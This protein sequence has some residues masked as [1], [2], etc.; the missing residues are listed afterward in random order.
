MERSAPKKY[1]LEQFI[2]TISI[3]FYSFIVIRKENVLKQGITFP[4]RFEVKIIAMDLVYLFDLLGTF[5]FAISGVM[6]AAEKRFDFVGAT[7]IG[8]VAALG[9]GTIRDVLMGKTPVGWMQDDAY[10]WVTFLSVPLCYFLYAQIKRLRKS[11][12]IFDTIG[13]ALFTILGVQKALLAELS[14]MVAVLMGVVSGVFGGVVRDVLSNEVPLIFRKELY[15]SLCLI[16]ASSYVGLWYWIGDNTWS[17]LLSIGWVS[18]LRF[19]SVRYQWELPF[20]P[21][22]WRNKKP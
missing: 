11:V 9:G 8:F 19:L 20:K 14:P 5:V 21:Y 18:V 6:T 22:Q 15:A 12:F 1:F 17:M 16:G 4:S 2:P 13:I 10:L 3:V 7:V